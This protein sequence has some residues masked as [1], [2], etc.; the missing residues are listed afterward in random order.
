MAI[1]LG[2]LGFLA[3]I[4]LGIGIAIFLLAGLVKKSNDFGDSSGSLHDFSRYPVHIIES[5]NN[6]K[7]NKW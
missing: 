6:I 3:G 5:Q 1:F 7:Y 4:F 2:F